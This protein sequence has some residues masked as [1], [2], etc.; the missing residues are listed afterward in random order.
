MDLGCSTGVLLLL[1]QEAG[2]TELAGLEPLPSAVEIACEARGLDVEV[3]WITSIPDDGQYDVVVLSHVLEHVLDPRAALGQVH[4]HL[5]P[6]GLLIVEVPNS[7][8]F[9][10][11]IHIPFQ[12]FNTEHINHFSPAILSAFVDSVGFECIELQ[13]DVA[14]AGPDHPYPVVRGAWRK[15]RA[16]TPVA[17]LP[18]E[19][20]AHRTALEAYAA[21][22]EALFTAIDRQ[23]IELVGS[24][25]FAVWGAG[26]FT[27]KWLRR[28]AFPLPQL[29][30]LVDSAGSRVG[31]SMMGN[32]VVHPDTVG[33]GDWPPV[34][35]TGSAYA[36]AAI[37][38]GAR[39]RGIAAAIDSPF[40]S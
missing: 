19:M 3:G 10:E 39:T 8:R 2:F 26:Q 33:S 29:D 22:S 38:K 12:D 4:H 9:H 15:G 16:A 6:G 35:L 23:T 28:S 27:M 18:G 30:L 7:H 40:P 14:G 13:Q 25:P 11:Y 21:K 36:A 17:T 31:L 5:A 37:R 20:S 32:E 1:L 24:Q 34:I